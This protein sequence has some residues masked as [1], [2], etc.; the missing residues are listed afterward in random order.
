MKGNDQSVFSLLLSH[1]P[2]EKL[3]LCY[4]LRL[5]RR[6]LH[7]CARCSGLFPAMLLT[8]VA[9]QLTG[10]WPWWFEWIMLFIP[11]LPAF[12][13]WG[14]TT[15]TGK[16]E[17]SNRLR[18]LTGVGLGIG[19]GAS[20][21][22]NTYALLSYPVMAQ[23]AFLLAAVW[24]VWMASYARRSR[25]RRERLKERLKNRPSLEEYLGLGEQTPGQVGQSDADHRPEQE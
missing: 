3:H 9:G 16:P 10:R 15:S 19:I 12:L 5:G 7:F 6:Q 23:L 4:R 20:L 24:V 25:L 17:R 8:L 13:D 21:H 14:T 2:V 1:H 22:I 18:F 11:V